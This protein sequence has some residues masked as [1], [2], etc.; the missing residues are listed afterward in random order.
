MRIKDL[1][2]AYDTCI[3]DN[4]AT[5]KTFYGSGMV[6]RRNEMDYA[7]FPLGSGILTS[8]SAVDEAELNEGG[9]MILGNDFG[10]VGYVE[11][12]RDKRE[13][14]SRTIYNLKRLGLDMGDTF[15]TNYFMGLRDDALHPGTTMTKRVV[16]L[17]EAYKG[18]CSDFFRVQLELVKPRMVVCLGADVGRAVSGYF[19][20]IGHFGKGPGLMKRYA[21][22]DPAGYTAF[23]PDGPN[24]GIKFILIPHP[25]FAHINWRKG[26][27]DKIKAAI[28]H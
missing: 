15:F 18:L 3:P 9:I 17:Q 6:N 28:N 13:N 27:K 21:K 16:R 1:F 25:S 22:E 2:I 24:G 20:G 11:E 5:R 4:E 19:N 7:F 23:L 14:S 12:L 26:I 10:T 8:K